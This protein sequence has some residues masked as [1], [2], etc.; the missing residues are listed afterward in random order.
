MNT[1][2]LKSLSQS[3][4]TKVVNDL[5]GDSENEIPFNSFD[6][7]AGYTLGELEF[8][9]LDLV[10]FMMNIDLL[11]CVTVEDSFFEVKEE[12]LEF[13]KNINFKEIA[14]YLYDLMYSSLNS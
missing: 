11:A 9:E 10:E 8:D 4:V 6:E 1:G 7:L 2:Y 13:N 14:D 3:I 5:I 12:E